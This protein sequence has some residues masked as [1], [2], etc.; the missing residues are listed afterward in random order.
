MSGRRRARHGRGRTPRPAGLARELRLGR[1]RRAD[2]PGRRPVAAPGGG[3][4][5]PARGPHRQPDR[6]HVPDG[7]VHR[8]PDPHLLDGVHARRPAL[9]A[10]LHVPVALL[11]LD[12][13]P[14][15]VGQRLHDLHLLGARRRLLLP[16]DRLLVRGQ[17]ERRRG[18]QGVHRQPGRRRGDAPRPGPAL[19]EPGHL[20]HR[21][22]QPI[23]PRRLGPAP[24]RGGRRRRRGGPDARP[25]VGPVADR[26]RDGPAPAD[27]PLGADAWPGWGSSPAASARVPSS[28]STSGSP[29]RWPGR[30]R[31][32]P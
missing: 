11:L 9:S 17:E 2:A 25:R 4:D 22:D 29:T 28:R 16:P 19:G 26:R 24:R 3:P 6:D 12:A 21:R 30:R 18:Q 10:V 7:H 27:R 14:G 5:D 15:G 31:S 8:D 20:Q 13:R 1:T 32:R 23:A